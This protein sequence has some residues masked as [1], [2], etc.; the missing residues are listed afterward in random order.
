M[1]LWPRAASLAAGGASPS[2]KAGV[3]ISWSNNSAA[4]ASSASVISPRTGSIPS[5]SAK[6][7][8]S[9]VMTSP[10]G[11]AVPPPSMAS[12]TMRSAIE[13]APCFASLSAATL[14]HDT[15]RTGSTSSSTVP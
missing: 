8:S 13:A 4:R 15:I 10:T 12:E 14:R 9:A 3:P 5:V 11:G 1:K 6:P 2:M 7:F